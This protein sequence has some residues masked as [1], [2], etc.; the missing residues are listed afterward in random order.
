MSESIIGKQNLEIADLKE[1]VAYLQRTLREVDT[2]LLNEKF[3]HEE[4]RK[5]MR[6]I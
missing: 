6:L 1:Q 4:T 5:Q 3:A 2:E